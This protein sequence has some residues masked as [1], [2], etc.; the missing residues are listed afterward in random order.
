MLFPKAAEEYA[1][2]AELYVKLE[3]FRAALSDWKSYLRLEPHARDAEHARARVAE[4]EP[5]VARLN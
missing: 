3:C 1:H 2:R 4:L 5:L